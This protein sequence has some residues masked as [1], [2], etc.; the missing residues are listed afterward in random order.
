MFWG[1]GK[2]HCIWAIALS[3]TFQNKTL[4]WL[5]AVFFLCFWDVWMLKNLQQYDVF[6]FFLASPGRCSFLLFDV[7]SISN[8][9]CFK[10]RSFLQSQAA[11][12]SAKV[13]SSMPMARGEE[14]VWYFCVSWVFHSVP[15]ITYTILLCCCE[16]CCWFFGSWWLSVS[17]FKPLVFVFA[18]V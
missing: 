13:F 16:L 12:I 15:V 4:S 14:A 7:P 1:E 9:C 18:S 8:I 5:F 2:T 17:S 10:N 6:F 11:K 3:S